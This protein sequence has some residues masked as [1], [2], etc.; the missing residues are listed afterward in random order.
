MKYDKLTPADMQKTVAQIV[1]D[2]DPLEEFFREIP[3]RLLAEP[4]PEQVFEEEEAQ[5]GEERDVIQDLPEFEL[6]QMP[7]Q[8][9][10]PEGIDGTIRLNEHFEREGEDLETGGDGLE[11]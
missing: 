2:R 9:Q 6:P 4:T 10:L 8:D 3:A 5:L 11:R 7:S 1:E